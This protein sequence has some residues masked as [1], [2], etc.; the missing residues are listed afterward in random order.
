MYAHYFPAHLKSFADAISCEVAIDTGLIVD[1]PELVSGD[2]LHTILCLF[3]D[4]HG[5]NDRRAAATDWSKF[6][7][8]RLIIPVVVIQSSTARQ[9]DL[10][11]NFWRIHCREDGTISRFVFSRD[12]LI[13]NPAAGDMASLVDDVMNPLISALISECSLSPRV[14]ASNAA[15]Y[16][17][18]ALDQLDQQNRE[19]VPWCRPARALLDSPRRPDGGCNPFYAPFKSLPANALDGNGEPTR[20][21]RRLCCVRDLDPSLGLCAD[22]PRAITYVTTDDKV[23]DDTR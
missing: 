11:P 5:I 12:P 3:A 23:V 1:G 16:Y 4:S 17:A 15:M 6:F 20:A 18:W 22:C 2:A 21:C 10:N 8:A 7:F 9:L 13:D 19:P 14:F